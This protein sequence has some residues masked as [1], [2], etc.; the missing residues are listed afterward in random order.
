MD[1]G[2]HTSAV[3]CDPHMVT[4]DELLYPLCSKG[5]THSAEEPLYPL[6]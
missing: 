6:Y 1:D 3:D 4:A 5:T 2:I